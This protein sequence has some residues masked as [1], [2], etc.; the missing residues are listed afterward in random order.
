MNQSPAPGTHVAKNTTVTIHVSKGPPQVPVPD[1]VGKSRD[2]AVSALTAAGL[3]A[4]VHTVHSSK[5]PD[6]VTAQ[7]PQG[8]TKV[9]K[10]SR[11]RINVS[12]GPQP[13]S[14]PYV[15]GLS[16]D[17]ASAQLQSAGFAV[18]RRNV[19]SNQPKDTVV[20]QDPTGSAAPGA[21]VTLSVSK[22][23]KQSTV[24]DV[25]NQDQDSATSTLQAAG[26]KVKVVKQDVQ[27]PGLDGIV[28]S[29]DPSGGTMAPQ[30]S[31]V[32]ITVGHLIPPGQ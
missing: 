1:V 8:G 5:T 11:V 10:G 17:Q 21:T 28:L 15:I 12:T 27:D 19:D 32:T 23:P 26:F 13:V 30:G 20:A 3:Q 29:E 24:P 14:V 22:G 18:A 31:T 6:T 4:N 25:T 9:I 2:D 7:D 16:F